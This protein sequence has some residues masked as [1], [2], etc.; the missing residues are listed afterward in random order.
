[1]AQE[2]IGEPGAPH[3]PAGRRGRR[4]V[5]AQGRIRRGLGPRTS[6]VLHEIR[7]GEDM[8]RGTENWRLIVAAA[9][10]LTAAGHAPFSRIAVYQWIWSR[11]P[12]VDHDR[13]TLDP[14]F[15]GM[16]GQR[17]RRN[18][19]RRRNPAAPRGTRSVRAGRSRQ[20]VTCRLMR[21][22]GSSLGVLQPIAG[23]PE[24]H[25]DAAGGSARFYASRNSLVC[26]QGGPPSRSRSFRLTN[27]TRSCEARNGQWL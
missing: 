10:A 6:L 13:P 12:R 14:T 20:R 22:S 1:M 26:A 9:R 15:Q 2:A 17:A 5:L 4:R 16:V 24:A 25:R 7:D 27:F 23:R 21:G 19:E 11:H 8:R 18:P 3:G